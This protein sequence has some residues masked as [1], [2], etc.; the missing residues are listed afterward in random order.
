VDFFRR[1]GLP[2]I[3]GV[4]LTLLAACNPI[5]Q[6]TEPGTNEPPVVDAGLDQSVVESASITLTGTASDPDGSLASISWSQSAGPTV[7]LN[8][9]DSLVADFIAPS[10][11]E[12]TVLI[13]RLTVSD[14]GGASAS[15]TITVV[16]DPDPTLNDAPIA[17]AGAAQTVLENTTATLD[18]GASSDSD[19]SIQAYSWTQ[20]A[21]GA[22]LVGLLDPTAVATTFTAPD[23]VVTA[24]LVFELVVT[25]NEGA[26]SASDLIVVTVIESGGNVEISGQVT[27]D[28]VPH[29]VDGGLDYDNI[30]ALP[31]RAVLVDAVDNS[32]QAILAT[33]TTDNA[34]SFSLSV[35][36]AINVFVRVRAQM[37]D[38][39][40][41]PAWDFSVVDNDGA[42]D[43]AASKPLYVLDSSIFN[44]G[45]SGVIVDLHAASGWDPTLRFYSTERSAAPFAILNVI[46]DA[47]QIT[48]DADPGVL[49]KALRI[50]WSPRNSLASNSIQGTFF[51]NEEMF[52]LGSEE[53]DTDEYDQHVI[54]HEFGHYLEDAVS[55]TDSVGGPHSLAENLDGR[56][57]LSEGWGNAFSAMVTGDEN[58]QDSCCLGQSSAAVDFSLEDNCQLQGQSMGWY[59]EC[60]VGS[61]LYDFFDPPPGEVEDTINTGFGPIY[62]VLAGDLATSPALTTVFSFVQFLKTVSPANGAA[63]DTLLQGQNIQSAAQD[64]FGAA[65]TDDG[66]NP[67]ALPVYREGL[68]VGGAALN[69]CSNNTSGE[70]NKLGN[71]IYVRFTID[72]TAE[73]N[74][75]AMTTDSVAGSSPDPDFTLFLSGFLAEG[76]S[77]PAIDETLLTSLDA[78]EYVLEVWDDNNISA[79]QIGGLDPGRYCVDLTVTVN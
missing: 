58:Y 24:N 30:Q 51:A 8:S 19:G 64:E 67:D 33:A 17:A 54:A 39:G 43:F 63:I 4:L 25:D 10:V 36:A 41:Q 42:L 16:A 53:Q 68:T 40:A 35:P 76:L 12:A 59:S 50:N 74:I 26:V 55:R 61:L 14:N 23:V 7:T 73:Y 1:Q 77:A 49:L 66:G 37:R 32:N 70:F 48:L 20:V 2:T 62:D 6:V 56:V 34:G 78:G 15:D 72:G 29:A 52:V 11:S 60:S 46:Y 45:V 65:E 31:A 69:V 71:R 5:D 21:N 75:R 13:F 27:F 22:P 9:G 38:T 57:A 28:M 44:S 3:R 79:S 47:W 18:G